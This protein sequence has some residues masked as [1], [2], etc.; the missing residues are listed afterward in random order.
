MIIFSTLIDEYYYIIICFKKSF[1]LLRCKKRLKK[2][3]HLINLKRIP[4]LLL[5][6]YYVVIIIYE[7]LFL[8]KLVF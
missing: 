1:P 6:H 5:K 2:K 7:F 8:T 3:N 4:K